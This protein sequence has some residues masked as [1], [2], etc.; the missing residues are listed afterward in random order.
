[1]IS[2]E[3][4]TKKLED[5]KPAPYNP[6]DIS[7]DSLEGLAN[8]LNEFGL[9]QPI[10]WN[11]RSGYIVGGHQRVKAMLRAGEKEAQVLVV[12]LDEGR[13][14]AL[15]LALNNPSIEGKFTDQLQPI[16]DR[17]KSEMPDLF[18]RL[19]LGN[20]IADIPSANLNDPDDIPGTPLPVTKLG[21]VWEMGDHLLVCGD[22]AS[23]EDVERCMGGGRAQA[24]FTDPPWNVAIGMDSNPKHRQREGLINDNLG[25][26]FPVF[27]SGW[28]KTCLPYLDGDLYCV[29]GCGEWPAIDK[30]LRDAGMHWSSTIVWVKDQFVLGRS[31]YHRRFEPIWY[32][33]R[34]D[35]LSS[36]VGDRKQ[37]DVWSIPRPKKSEEHPTMKPVALVEKAIL[38][39][40]QRGDV[41]LDMFAG[42]GTTAIACER[43][44]R[45]ARLIELDPHYCDVI[46]ARWE[47]FSGKKA[48]LL[49]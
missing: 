32:G 12:D 23:L 48:S 17:L 10:V 27:L 4:T 5:L 47:K 1:M 7:D 15:N 18:D 24:I 6:R 45:R 11:K 49:K 2:H 42:S 36:Y 30:A 33:W 35:R 43:T 26:A 34:G 40:T 25:D 13:E 19:L 3:I 37:D 29:M 41:V 8:S 28:A 38:N 31:K 9:V 39:S 44:G 20:L 16:L 22:A 46:V 21:D 14:R